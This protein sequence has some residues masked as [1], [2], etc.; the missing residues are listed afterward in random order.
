MDWQYESVAQPG[1]AGPPSRAAARPRARR[2]QQPQRHGLPARLGRGLRRLG[3]PAAARAGAGTRCARPSRSSRSTCSPA[4]CRSATRFSQVFIDAAVEAGLPFNPDF[5]AGT[6]DGCGWNRST[7]VDGRRRN[8]YRAFLHPVLDR[9]NLEVRSDAV[10]ERLLIDAGGAVTGVELPRRR[11]S[12]RIDGRRGGRR[13]R[14]V[15]LAAAPAA[16]RHRPGG[17]PRGRRH[18]PRRRPA[19]RPPPARPPADRRRL[20]LEAADPVPAPARHGVAA[21]SRAPRLRCA[22]ATSR[23]PSTRRCT[24]R[25]RSTTARRATRS[26]PASPSCAAA[27]RC[28]SCPATA[29]RAWRSTPATSAS[30][31]TWRR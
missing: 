23:S 25:R 21:R 8:S 28:G 22:A 24:S 2:H 5:D 7:I 18:R 4:T 11:A 31:R 15:R 19:R 30:P 20:R 1:T 14:R 29:A 3:R 12:E 13:G 10:V 16:L 27:A 6:L 9:P 17:R 26:S